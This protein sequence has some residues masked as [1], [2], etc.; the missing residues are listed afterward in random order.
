[1]PLM[2]GCTHR[3]RGMFEERRVIRTDGIA[4]DLLLYAQGSEERPKEALNSRE[5]IMS[6][7]LHATDLCCGD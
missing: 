3:T 4:H 6:S 5:E 2:L 7:M 1:M